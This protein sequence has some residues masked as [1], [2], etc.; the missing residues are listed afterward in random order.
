MLNYQVQ[1]SGF[2]ITRKGIV[3]RSAEGN[4]RNVQSLVGLTAEVACAETRQEFFGN[5]GQQRLHLDLEPESHELHILKTSR[6]EA[7]S[8]QFCKQGCEVALR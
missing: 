2:V 5:V 6:R 7:F 3:F 1:T 8:G 4:V